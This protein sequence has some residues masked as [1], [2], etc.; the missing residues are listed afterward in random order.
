M[1]RSPDLHQ[2][3]RLTDGRLRILNKAVFLPQR[4]LSFFAQEL[5]PGDKDIR[6]FSE[7]RKGPKM[8]AA[9]QCFLISQ[10]PDSAHSDLKKYASTHCS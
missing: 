8:L 3:T 10:S 6:A 2:V 7:E 5:H 4:K 9:D 1:Q